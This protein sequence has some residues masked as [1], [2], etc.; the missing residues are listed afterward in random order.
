M[1]GYHGR[2]LE[3]N[4]STRTKKDLS[5]SEEFCRKYIGG[6]T[7]AAALVYDRLTPDTDPLSPENPL[8]MSTSLLINSWAT[9]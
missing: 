8:V 2:F 6:A 9:F 1:Y 7:M 4:L 3:V 5:I